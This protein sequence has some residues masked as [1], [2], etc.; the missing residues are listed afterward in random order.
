[1]RKILLSLL[2]LTMLTLTTAKA[3]EDIN[4]DEWAAGCESKAVFAAGICAGAVANFVEGLNRATPHPLI[5]W[6]PSSAPTEEWG[7]GEY[8]S[9]AMVAVRYFHKNPS[10]REMPAPALMLAAFMRQWPCGQAGPLRR[11]PPSPAQV[12]SGSKHPT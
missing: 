3:S 9:L 12:P 2:G 7:A 10:Y 11:Y 8:H 5:C 1:M 4:A 6:P